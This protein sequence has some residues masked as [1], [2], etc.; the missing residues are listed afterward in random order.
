M[1]FVACGMKHGSGM[2]NKYVNGN[3]SCITGHLG[4]NIESMV[5]MR[6]CF[7]DDIKYMEF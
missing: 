5:D 2:T 3:E 6:E 7:L 1:V 4:K